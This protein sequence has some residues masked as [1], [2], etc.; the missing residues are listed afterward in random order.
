MA[1]PQLIYIALVALSLGMNFAQHGQPRKPTDGWAALLSVLI[2]VPLLWWGG[3]FHP[4][5]KGAL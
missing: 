4:L 3:F 1:W 5:F 2:I